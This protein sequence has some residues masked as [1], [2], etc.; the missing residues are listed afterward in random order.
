MKKLLVTTALQ[1]TWGKDESLFFIGE[2]CKEYDQ[3]VVWEQRQSDVLPY[4][5]RDR[6]KH[7]HDYDYLE[8][9]YERVLAALAVSLN[10]YHNVDRP[11]KYWRLILGPWLIEYVSVVW[12][13]WENLRIAF[14][15]WDFDTTLVIDYDISNFI[16]KDY[17]D[18]MACFNNH[19]WNHLLFS[20]ILK[21]YYRD[22]IRIKTVSLDDIS[23]HKN[24]N[25]TPVKS[26]KWRIAYLIDDILR[27][28]QINRKI[29]IVGGYFHPKALMKIAIKLGQLPRLHH[30][31]D[32][33]IAMPNPSRIKK[34]LDFKFSSNDSF[35]RFVEQH[36]INHIPVAYMEG[37]SEIKKEVYKSLPNCDIIFTANSHY[38][39]E[40]FKVWCAEMIELNKILIVSA[41]GGALRSLMA[42]FFHEEKI[43]YKKVVWQV[44]IFT[45]HVKLSPNKIINFNLNEEIGRNITIVGLELDAYPRRCASGPG[46][47]LMLDDYY[48]K[49]S[50]VNMLNDEVKLAL[51]IRPTTNRGWNTKQRYIDDLG[52]DKISPYK[53]YK[54]AISHSRLLVCTY[55]QTTFFEAM[56]SGVPTILLYTDEYWEL[57]AE[58]DDLLQTLKNAKIIFSDAET[59]AQHVNLIWDD[60]E[61]WWNN[62]ITIQARENF[63]DSCGRVSDDWQVEWT[64]FFKEELR[65]KI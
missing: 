37:Y 26:L 47:S 56:Y 21:S 32:K 65:T 4:H 7:R 57:G 29:V 49:I 46:A 55:P 52:M 42:G 6:T 54:E 61:S 62:A 19:L 40:L 22:R 1:K 28:V 25:A 34:Q 8:Q 3:K 23:L 20:E 9:Y 44:P 10:K 43:S 50:F 39:N 53:T 17:R 13:R 38:S 11:L 48:Q 59:A 24:H 58:F 33:E 51:Q 30:E 64:E 41:H 14:D 18:V 63:F 36:I 16:A 45:N 27:R 15:K 60:I 31:F 2:W 12:D 35:E 5:W